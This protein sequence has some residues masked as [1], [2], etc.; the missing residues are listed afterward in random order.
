MCVGVGECVYWAVRDE[1]GMP[2]LLEQ[3]RTVT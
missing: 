2:V 3:Q 1:W